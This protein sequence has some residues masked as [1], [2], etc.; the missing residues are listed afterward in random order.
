M[1]ETM[2]AAGREAVLEKARELAKLFR[3]L[4]P[5]ADRDNTF[6]FGSIEPF[7][8]SG[9]VALN[10]PKEYGGMGGDMLITSQVVAELS[11]GDSAIA[12]AY[13]MHFITVA[14]TLGLLDED[15]KKQWLGR[16]VEGDIM[17]GPISEK[18]AGFSGLADMKAVPQPEG[19]YR[20]YGQKNWGTNCEAADILISTVTITDADG[21]MPKD[22]EQWVTNERAIVA[23]FK[24]DDNGQGDGIRIERT[25]DAMGMHATGTHVIHFE[26]FYLPEE[27]LGEEWR[28][29]AFGVLEWA[30]ILFASI[31]YGM[32]LRILDEAREYLAEKNLGATFGAVVGAE[33]KTANIGHIAAGLGEIA[34]RCEV[35]RRVLWQ[36]CADLAGDTDDWPVLLRFPYICI[37]KTTVAQNVVH[38]SQRA[39][40]LVGGSG[41]RRGT[42]FERCYRDAAASMFQPLNAD[43]T[44]SYIGE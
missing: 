17:F 20:I 5:Q 24:V 25:W 44:S 12:L 33:T 7:R 35:S 30:E 9:L 31:Y 16:V 37:A 14:L 19:G 21:N 39:L 27:N 29:G 8:Q 18:R 26:G 1:S 36:T 4:G 43:Q 13:N 22:F 3:E 32:Q 2:T 15:Q 40:S 42:I 38:C 41:Y 34:V 11:R 10:V 6:A 23:E 28:A